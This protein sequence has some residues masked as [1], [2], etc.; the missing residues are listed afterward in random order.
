MCFAILI[1]K[2]SKKIGSN[3]N[4]PKYQQTKQEVYGFLTNYPFK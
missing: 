3:V 2:G 4:K 1:C